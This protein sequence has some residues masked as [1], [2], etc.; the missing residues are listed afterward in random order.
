[1]PEYHYRIE[2]WD[3]HRAREA[4]HNLAPGQRRPDPALVR[5]FKVMF[6]KGRW[7]PGI[8]TPITFNV[9]G[10]MTNGAHRATMIASL[11]EGVTVPVLVFRGMP[12]WSIDYFDSGRNRSMGNVL[13]YQFPQE[14][15]SACRT[16]A[17]IAQLCMTYSGPGSL[18]RPDVKPQADAMV[19]WAL[20][21]AGDLFRATHD[22]RTIVAIEKGKAGSV[23]TARTIGFVLFYLPESSQFFRG[24]A[25]RRQPDRD[26]RQALTDYYYRKPLPKGAQGR[27]VTLQRI[28]DLLACYDAGMRSI[29]WKTWNSE[30]STFRHPAVN[31]VE[32]A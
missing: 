22:A 31:H 4:L 17:A 16:A 27:E 26:P 13:R 14:T 29:R 32:A 7:H 25:A 10:V 2:E 28:A 1:M 18:P 5:V 12:D 3:R 19:R 6:E 8:G 30:E 11:P 9:S 20:D 23:M 24:L 21:H 15:E